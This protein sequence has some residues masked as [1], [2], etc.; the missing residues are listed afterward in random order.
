M[1]EFILIF[2]FVTLT[3]LTLFS[4]HGFVMLYYH[5]KYSNKF[6]VKSEFK[7]DKVVT[8][9]LPLYN[10]MY[11][12]ERLIDA[13]CLIEY[14]KELLEIQVLDDSTDETVDIVAAKVEQKRKEGFDIKQIRRTNR[15]GYK[16]GALREGLQV[17][18]GEYVAIFDADFIPKPNFLEN[19]L[20]YFSDEKIGMVQSRWE[21][22]NE[23]YSLLTKVQALALN[24]HFVIEQS[25][26]NKSGFF[27]NF[28]GTGGV[29]RK[30]CIED[31]GNWQDDTIT[32]DLDLS[33]RAQLRGWKFVFLR[34][35]TTPAELPAEM[36]ALKAQQFRWT[37][38]AVE[39]AKKILP[40]VWATDISLRVKLQATFHLTN[41][42]VFPFILTAGILNVPLVFI[43]N[44]GP[45]DGF[46]NVMS[47]FVLAFISSFLFY[48]YAQ[49][50]VHEDW[51]KRIVLF[52]L[53]MAGSMGL[54]VN[55]TRAVLE[56]LVNKKTEFV[57]TPKFKVEKNSDSFVSNK[58]LKKTKVDI[59]TYVEF[60]L[61][62]YCLIGVVASIYFLELAALPFH[63]M[64]FIGFGTVSLLS[65]KQAFIKK[66]EAVVEEK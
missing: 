37:K 29:W 35:F 47:I 52:P 16:A 65:L 5:K 18:R 31:A 48:L 20:A 3:I 58:Y 51:R 26:R 17:A 1:N 49:K 44:S 30:D 63:L 33:Y 56:G 4:G 50:D 41:N 15:V 40:K 54:A 38:G 32:E 64:F 19:T 66:K 23:N 11:V 57:R 53:F 60:I 6:P 21:H 45:Y 24:G 22:L 7:K 9:Q 39:T 55:N 42:I 10:E 2:Y 27:I 61:A 12:V 25:V 62:L 59:S 28:N 43:K 36:N 46:F 34:D 14:P 8:I 13:V